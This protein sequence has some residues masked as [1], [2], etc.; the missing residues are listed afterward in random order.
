VVERKQ[1]R[2]LDKT[3]NDE[4]VFLKYADCWIFADNSSILLYPSYCLAK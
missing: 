2:T 4:P 3:E 1:M